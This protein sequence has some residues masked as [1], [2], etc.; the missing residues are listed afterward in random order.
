MKSNSSSPSKAIGTLSPALVSF[1]SAAIV[2]P[3]ASIAE[4]ALESAMFAKTRPLF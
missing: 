3:A 1:Q 4:T 2:L